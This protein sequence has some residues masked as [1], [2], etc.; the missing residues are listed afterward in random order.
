MGKFEGILLVS[1]IDA[2]LF[3]SEH[4]ISEENAQAIEYFKSEG[5]LFSVASGRMRDAV[6]NYLNELKINAPTILHNGAKIYDFENN[7][8]LY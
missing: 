3:N 5:G 6:G 4:H 1:D 7:V 8:T 2:T